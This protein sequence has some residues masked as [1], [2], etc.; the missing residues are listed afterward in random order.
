[1]TAVGLDYF[2]SAPG[3]ATLGLAVLLTIG[4]W[5]T[6]VLIER[7]AAP[8]R[9]EASGRAGALRRESP[10]TV[11]VLTNDCTLTAAGFRAT[12]IDLASRGWLRILP[13][14]TDDELGRVRPAATAYDGDSLLPHERLVLQ[15]VLAR[16]TTDRA[17]P[18]RHLAV[19]V[20]GSW[21]KRFQKLVYDDARR[22]GLVKR[23]W[24]P[25]LLTGPAAVAGFAAIAWLNSR[26]A[27]PEVAVIDSLERRIIA[28]ATLIGLIALIVRIVRH[29]TGSELTHTEAGIA[30]TS[31]WLA[32]R[33]R[34]VESGFGP[35]APSSLEPG[36]R[37]LAYA[38]AM[39]LAQGAAIELPL[40]RED[41][42]RAWSSVGGEARLVRVRYPWRP[43][44][45]TNPLIAL[46]GGLAATFIGL[47]LRRWFSDIAR[48]E[49]LGS[50]YERFPDQDWLISDI[51][52]GL[53]VLTY[54]PIV[55]GLWAAF[56]GAADMFNTVERTGVVLR[57]RRP[58]EVSPLPRTV[59]RRIERDRYT[60]FVAIDDGA[61]DTLTA[62][63]ATE[64]TAMPQGVDAV[65]TATP[66]LGYIR[67][68]DP[69]GHPLPD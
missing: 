65:V 31:R 20:R 14:E 6:M 27:N 48:E 24:T 36:D 58:A 67:R 35:M 12:V 4:G 45:G 9:P 19:D 61:D 8:R 18:A 25:L 55:L 33:R 7:S 49:A 40:A 52:T 56:A 38:S 22:S 64:R 21:W 13:P 30:A 16:F 5:V 32:V 42:R 41:H 51:A 54:V 26:E 60:L 15:H 2:A 39:C 63:R 46:T 62:W 47:R 3:G 69:I 50:V 66:L 10:A 1:M 53:T 68:A 43:I 17:I 59:R 28:I 11:N 44:Y 37:R 34:L 29:A 23:R 57:T